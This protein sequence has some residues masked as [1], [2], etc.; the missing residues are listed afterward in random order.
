MGVQ[1]IKWLLYSSPKNTRKKSMVN[2]DRGSID[3]CYLEFHHLRKMRPSWILAVV[4]D[5]DMRDPQKW[6]GT[7][8]IRICF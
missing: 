8:R 6:V 4:M 3:N 2:D 1:K 5:K 7:L